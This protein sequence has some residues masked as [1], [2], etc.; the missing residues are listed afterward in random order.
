MSN[1]SFDEQLQKILF[2]YFS[3][4][5]QAEDYRDAIDAILAAIREHLPEKKHTWDFKKLDTVERIAAANG[6][7]VALDDVAESLGL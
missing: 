2:L 3:G 4:S 1:Q 5:A 7:N 6:Y